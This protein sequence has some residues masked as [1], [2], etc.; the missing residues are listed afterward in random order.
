MDIFV[1]TAS[2]R[3]VQKMEIASLDMLNG[4]RIGIVNNG[5]RSMDAMVPLLT[6]RLKEQ[7]GV[8]QVE[9][10]TIGLQ[11]SMAEDILDKIVAECD[12]AVVGLAN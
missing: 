6:R 10:F 5:W 11:H 2:A 3:N 12:A 1:P 9:V 4:K 8:R 7:Y